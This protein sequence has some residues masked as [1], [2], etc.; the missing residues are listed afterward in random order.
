[1]EQNNDKNSKLA[2]AD[3]DRVLMRLTNS[4]E[5][6]EARSWDL[7]Q[8]RISEAV[9]LEMA[10]E[11]MTRD[12]M[13]LLKAYL[14]RDLKRLGYYA[15][16]TGAGIAAWLRFDLDALEHTL[17]SQLKLIAD[18]TRVEQESLR[19]CLDHAEDQYLAGELATAGT[20]ECLNCGHSFSLIRTEKLVP[21]AECDKGYFKRI[22]QPWS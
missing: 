15:H 14:Q 11:E 7:L 9:E 4:L 10:A 6:S 5:N 18:K 16:E 2:S 1:M 22:S 13:D 21:C 12:E 8:E 3:Y 17:A 19:E 20:L